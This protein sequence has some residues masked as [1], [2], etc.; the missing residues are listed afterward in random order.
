[1]YSEQKVVLNYNQSEISIQSIDASS[2]DWCRRNTNA[3]LPATNTA[4]SACTSDYLKFP[5]RLFS[6][7]TVLRYRYTASYIRNITSSLS[8]TIQLVKGTLSSLL[9]EFVSLLTDLSLKSPASCIFI[10]S[11]KILPKHVIFQGSQQRL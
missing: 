3:Y 4:I 9:V 2:S 10:L 5:Q 11:S 7:V 6:A 1:M 8:H